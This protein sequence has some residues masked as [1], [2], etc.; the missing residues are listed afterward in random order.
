MKRR[1]TAGLGLIA[2]LALALV[3]AGLATPGASG[4]SADRATSSASSNVSRHAAATT[5]AEQQRIEDY[6]TPDR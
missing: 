2:G 1:M 3:P 6:W 5:R 4:A